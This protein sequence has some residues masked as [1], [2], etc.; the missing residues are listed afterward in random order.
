MVTLASVVQIVPKCL[1]DEN[2]LEHHYFSI[3]PIHKTNEFIPYGVTLNYCTKCD[4]YLMFDGK[5]EKDPKKV[6]LGHRYIEGG[7]T[8]E[9]VVGDIEIK[10][11][12]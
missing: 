1:D 9:E 6:I 10:R 7:S 11:I 5:M 3:N 12:N 8:I 4:S 2:Y